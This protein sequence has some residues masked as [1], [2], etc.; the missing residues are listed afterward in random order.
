MSIAVAK[1]VTSHHSH[2]LIEDIL[3]QADQIILGKNLQL[4]LAFCCLLANGHLLIEDIPGVGKTTLVRLLGKTLGL[5][6]NRIQFTNDMLPADI[7]GTSIFDTELKSFH[8]HYGPIFGQMIIADE[9]NRAT[10]KTQSACLQAMEERKVTVDGTTYPL[11]VPF[12]M[13]ATQNPLEQAGTYPLPES[14][15]DRFLMRVEI[16][17]PSESAEKLLLKGEKR[18]KLIDELKPLMDSTQLVE[19]QNQVDKI[20]ASDAIIDYIHRLL[21][22]TRNQSEHQWGLSP[23]AGLALLKAGKAWAFIEGRQ[24]VVPDDI[25]AIASSVISHRLNRGEG[26]SLGVTQQITQEILR[27]VKVD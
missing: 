11:P 26:L 5:K 14:Q 22:F 7:L 21:N 27:A 4:K 6:T 3:K 2:Y 25:Q 23:R 17:Y 12:F 13:V 8:F 10:P 16:G 20:H 24:F 9:L 1:K 18:E 15:L 19:M